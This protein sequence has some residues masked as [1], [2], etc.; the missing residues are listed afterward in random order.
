MAST[1]TTSLHVPLVGGTVRQLDPSRLADHV[2]RLHAYA[3]GLCGDRD[4]AQD[5]VQ[6]TYARVLAKPRRLRQ[7]DDLRYLLRALRNTYFLQLRKER[8]QPRGMEISAASEPVDL[9]GFMRPE[10]QAEAREVFTAISQL[11]E[12]FRFALL[13]VDVAGLSYEE[14][15]TLLHVRTGTVRSRLF[16]ARDR[17]ADLL[18]GGEVVKAS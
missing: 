11:P 1:T 5:L 3:W 14:A 17:M 7:D 15:S 10:R 18:Y 4:L 6:E 2:D 12:D 16:R 9:A 8:G 13:A